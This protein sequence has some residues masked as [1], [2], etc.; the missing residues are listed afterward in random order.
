[1]ISLDSH[2]NSSN[3]SPDRQTFN[4]LHQSDTV[5]P[6]LSPKLTQ[7]PGPTQ[8]FP[9]TSPALSDTAHPATLHHIGSPKYS[10]PQELFPD[11]HR[12]IADQA[13]ARH[14]VHW[15]IR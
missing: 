5:N 4:Y 1:M 14:T 3:I 2:D 7:A 12:P 15:N 10:Q 8:L 11:F 13:T 9:P 6:T